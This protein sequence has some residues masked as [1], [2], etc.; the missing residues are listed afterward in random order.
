MVQIP[1]RENQKVGYKPGWQDEYQNWIFGI[2]EL[3][4]PVPAMTTNV[5]KDVVKELTD[6]QHIPTT[7][8]PRKG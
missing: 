3:I 7:L 5:V 6:R 1:S 8:F 2:I 4:L